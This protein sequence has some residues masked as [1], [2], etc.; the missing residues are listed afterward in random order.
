[1]KQAILIGNISSKPDHQVN[2]ELYK[3]FRDHSQYK[4][5]ILYPKTDHG[6]LWKSIGKCN[7]INIPLHTIKD[8]LILLCGYN[9][10][11]L[12]LGTFN[13]V[14]YFQR[15]FIPD[16]NEL[17]LASTVET[18]V[19]QS[20][21]SA[22]QT[23]HKLANSNI[24]TKIKYLYPWASTPSAITYDAKAILETDQLFE[25]I[26]GMSAGKTIIAPDRPPF[27][28]LISHG[29]NGY[30]YTSQED[31]N[32]IRSEALSTSTF[33]GS[34]ARANLR[35]MMEPHRYLARL[36]SPDTISLPS[37]P[38]VKTKW[39]VQQRILESGRISLFPDK[40]SPEFQIMLLHDPL[41]ILYDL[42]TK[43]F[44][45]VYIFGPEFNDPSPQEIFEIRTLI[46]AMGSKALKIHFCIDEI[47]PKWQPILKKLSTISV[48]EGLKQVQVNI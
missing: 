7:I 47:P 19:C 39:I 38:T 13:K 6:R 43:P 14:I 2:V 3:L 16:P 30:L 9:R 44:D 10:A 28:D 15:G 23:A 11:F 29:F 21:C 41:S 20:A 25:A 48:E 37:L 32:H 24:R 1:M 35:A 27:S 17:L 46:N 26:Q 31:L 8:S 5:S 22:Y 33:V 45:E 40:F 12:S 18:I 4:T 34:N 36:L 42:S